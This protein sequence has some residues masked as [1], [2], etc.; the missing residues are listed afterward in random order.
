MHAKSG[1]HRRRGRL[2][3]RRSAG[4][5]SGEASRTCGCVADGAPE[6]ATI[7]HFTTRRLVGQGAAREVV[8]LILKGSAALGRGRRRRRWHRRCC[9]LISTSG[10]EFTSPSSDAAIIFRVQSYM[11]VEPA[12]E[13]SEFRSWPRVGNH[14]SMLAT[15]TKPLARRTP[16]GCAPVGG[17][18]SQIGLSTRKEILVT[19]LRL[20]M[21][22]ELQR[23]N[24]SPA[25]I[26]GYL[27][28]VE[29]FAKH[30]G[31]TPDKLG[32]DETQKLSGLPAHEAQPGR[33]KRGGLVAALR[34]F[35]VRTLK[36]R[37]FS[38]KSCLIRRTRRIG[39][40]S[41]RCS[42]WTRSPGSCPMQPA[43]SC[44]APY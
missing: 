28:A 8:E 41:R 13:R 29:Q 9:H 7:C 30:F 1:R 18:G 36:R 42:V 27:L 31:K 2:L 39:A 14:L 43:T 40:D 23:R 12:I 16:P 32:P 17:G 34:F 11:D 35:F 20:R 24:Y 25:T 19:N 3:G 37:D 15:R 26:R 38:G 4:H 5:S 44:N 22:A 21:L 6:L 10:S 33:G